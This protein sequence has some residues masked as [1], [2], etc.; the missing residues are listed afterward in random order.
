MSKPHLTHKSGRLK[1]PSLRVELHKRKA[2]EQ[3]ELEQ[4]RRYEDLRQKRVALDRTFERV[5]AELLVRILAVGPCSVQLRRA[6]N[7]VSFQ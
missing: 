2:L 1:F 3:S 5:K 6:C 4:E 7:G